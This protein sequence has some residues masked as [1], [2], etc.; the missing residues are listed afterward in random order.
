[1]AKRL[2]KKVFNFIYW[3]GVWIKNIAKAVGRR[4]KNHV[5]YIARYLKLRCLLVKNILK[6]FLR[7]TFNHLALYSRRLKIL[8]LLKPAGEYSAFLRQGV[9]EK[10]IVKNS[11]YLQIEK[12]F[13]RFLFRKRYKKADVT[14]LQADSLLPQELPQESRLPFAIIIHVYYKDVGLE[15]FRAIS[16][17]RIQDFK[18]II[19]TH[20][21]TVE[22]LQNFMTL[23]PPNISSRVSPVFVENR[24][25]DSAPF[26][27]ALNS[28][29]IE[30]CTVFLKLH[31]KK[32][33]HLDADQGAKWRSDLVS[34][35]LTYR[36]IDRLTQYL[37]TND[38]PV[39]ACPE[40]WISKPSQWGFNSFFVW[41]ITRD[42][43][44]EFEP[45]IEF[46][47]GNMYWFN[48]PLAKILSQ[49]EVPEYQVSSENRLTD[50][51]WAHAIERIPG[52][53]IRAGGQIVAIQ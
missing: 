19:L 20:S 50:G 47:V 12:N 8:L 4:G 41:R 10:E 5:F 6:S 11:T 18:K 31:T 53:I 17:S 3:R 43:G 45:R 26:I 24:Y 40:N 35:L 37:A 49:I 14:I 51:T 1:M 52:Q 33:P 7:F 48:F 13:I 22:G 15:L 30:G 25:R 32:S 9:L 27:Q 28:P 29:H 21:M 46:P 2:I 38:S 16:V 39:W 42:L 44:I 23:I 34:Q 36:N